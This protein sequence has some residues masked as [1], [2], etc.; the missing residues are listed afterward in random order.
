VDDLGFPGEDAAVRAELEDEARAVGAATLYRRLERLDPVAASRIEPGN[1]RRI[2][3]AL[4]VPAITGTP[5]SAFGAS[6]DRYDPAR[7]EVV[8]IRIEPA[9]LARRIARRVAAMLAGGWL[10]EVR[11]LVDRGF[12]GWLT[13]TQAIGYSELAWHLDGRLSLEEAREGTVRRTRNLARRQMAWFRRDP[14]VRWV[15]AGAG[16]AADVVDEALDRLGGA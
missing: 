2:V 16:G 4:E 14:R 1:V 8:G 12:G 13:A 5:F 6:W 15:A 11:G 3:R 7:A 9:V 10:D